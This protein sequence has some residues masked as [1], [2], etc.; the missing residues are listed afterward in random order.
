MIE[1][2]SNYANYFFSKLQKAAEI[3]NGNSIEQEEEEVCEPVK[4]SKK[5]QKP[6]KIEEEEEEESNVKKGEGSEENEEKDEEEDN[7]EKE[8]ATESPK[9]EEDEEEDDEKKDKKTVPMNEHSKHL[10]KK[11]YFQR[12]DHSRVDSLKPELKDNSFMVSFLIVMNLIFR[13]PNINSG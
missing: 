10:A 6:E 13:R 2:F 12:I 7:K 1:Y 3:E 5:T 4:K 9:E 11:N 8:V